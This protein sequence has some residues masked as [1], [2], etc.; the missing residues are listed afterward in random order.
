MV[1]TDSPQTFPVADENRSL[2]R[3]FSWGALIGVLAMTIAGATIWLLLTDPVSVTSAIDR[4]EVGSLMLQ[5][6]RAIYEAMAGLL[7]YL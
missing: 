7:E 4:G 3:I 5:L 2:G 1:V 6:A